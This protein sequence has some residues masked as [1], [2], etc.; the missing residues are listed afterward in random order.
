MAFARLIFRVLLGTLILLAVIGMFLPDTAQVERSIVINAPADKIF[1]HLNS[2]RA[3]HAWS[4]W[5][6]VDPDT[7]Y[8][9]EGPEQGVGSRMTWS[10]GDER[11][12][13]GSQ[14]ITASA[15]NQSVDTH[16]VFGDEGEGDARFVLE[17]E[18][19]GT[20]IRWE[21]ETEFGWDLF[22]RYVGLMLDTMIGTSYDRGLKELKSRIEQ[23]EAPA[24][25]DSNA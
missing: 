16:L 9:F 21:F 8:T 6:Q 10:S 19:Q 17:P 11:V 5:T 1:P 13:Q 12:G 25:P 20:R 23:P 24:E 7:S 4:P 14:E 2:M 18:G 15:P 22:G 3:F